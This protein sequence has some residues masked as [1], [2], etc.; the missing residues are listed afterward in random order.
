MLS[1]KTATTPTTA[2]VIAGMQVQELLKLVHGLPT[3]NGEGFVFEGLNHSSYKVQYTE[4]EECLSHQTFQR[5]VSLPGASVELTLEHIHRRAQSDLGSAEV[6]VEFSRDII[7]KLVCR[8]CGSEEEIFAPVGTIPYSRG[9]C[10]RDGKIREVVALHTYT[11]SEAFGARPLERVGLPAFDIFS[12][13]SRKGEVQYLI[14][15]DAG[16][17]L[18][19]LAGSTAQG[20]DDLG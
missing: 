1:G 12:A 13:R 6:C 7:H 15:G 20:T 8:E 11:G 14:A 4:N 5:V 2:S 18:G 19:P 9:R 3:L 16:V 10:S 17:V